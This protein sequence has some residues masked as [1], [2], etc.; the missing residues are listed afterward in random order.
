MDEPEDVMECIVSLLANI[1]HETKMCKQINKVP[2]QH[3]SVT[4]TQNAIQGTQHNAHAGLSHI[5]FHTGTI[6]YSIAI[7]IFML[8]LF[9]LIWYLARYLGCHFGCCQQRGNRNNLVNTRERWNNLREIIKIEEGRK[10]PGE[11]E[12]IHFSP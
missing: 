4:D 11:P 7:I 12:V 1:T 2:V 6:L 9:A 8:M 3:T 10:D 5:P